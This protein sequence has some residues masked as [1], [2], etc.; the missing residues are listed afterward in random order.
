MTRSLIALVED[1]A[2]DEALM[3]EAKEQIMK[4]TH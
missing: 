1:N 3:V 2:D 4:E